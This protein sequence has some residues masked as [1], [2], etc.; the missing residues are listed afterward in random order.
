M[1][2]IKPSHI[3]LSVKDTG[4]VTSST[5]TYL[6]GY[7]FTLFGSN[8]NAIRV[9]GRRRNGKLELT[10][11][12]T[13]DGRR[14]RGKFGESPDS[15]TRNYMMSLEPGETAML[16]IDLNWK[17][18]KYSVYWIDPE[19]TPVAWGRASVKMLTLRWPNILRR[20]LAPCKYRRMIRETE[21]F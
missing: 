16:E 4:V 2:L 7:S 13:Q 17:N 5:Y 11:D 6:Y 3:T 12:F 15:P 14:K 1:F 20:M 19:G 9:M 21:I 8:R 18:T 10:C